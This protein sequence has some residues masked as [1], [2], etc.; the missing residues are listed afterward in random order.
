MI[1]CTLKLRLRPAQER[2]LGHWLWK[3]TAVW[4]WTVRK[5]ELDA[6]DRQACSWYDIQNL[7]TGHS[8]RV[9]VPARVGRKPKRVTGANGHKPR[10]RP[11]AP[12]SLGNRII[13][14]LTEFQAPMKRADLVEKVKARLPDVIAEM[15]ALRQVDR[16]VMVGERAG[17][18]YAVPKFAHVLVAETD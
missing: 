16:I 14:V 4:N 10:R 1:S 18:R 17:A 15:K 9:G 12:G 6:H 13:E 3:L 2:I 8:S 11:I 5:I 7:L